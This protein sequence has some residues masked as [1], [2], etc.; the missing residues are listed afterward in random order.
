M[1][2]LASI[3]AYGRGAPPIDGR[4]LDRTREAMFSRGPDGAGTWISDDRTIGLGHRRLAIIDLT[5]S[6][7]QPMATADGTLRIIL[8]GEIFN[9][10]EL[11]RELEGAGHRFRSN[12]DTEVLLLMYR[13]HGEDMVSRLRGMY[14]FALW[15]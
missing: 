8:N 13:E 1:C 10:R 11:R 12:S 6:G 3:F 7:A 9:Y 15:D 14:A 4:G 2:G 5:P